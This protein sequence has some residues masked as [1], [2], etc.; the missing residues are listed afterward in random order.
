MLPTL[1]D[2]VPLPVVGMALVV[3]FFV[4]SEMGFAA[5]GRFGRKTG[6]GGANDEA[7]VLATALLL[8][9]LLLGFTFSM[10]LGRYDTRRQIVVQE[11]NDIGTA[12]LRAGLV[13]APAGKALQAKLAEYARSRVSTA[14]NSTDAGVFAA[15]MALG[16]ALRD[17]IWGLTSAAIAP[18]R[19]TAQAAALVAS[20]NAVLDTAT[21]RAAAVDARVPAKVIDLLIVYAGVSTFL[22]GYVLAAYGS[23]H[24]IATLVLFILLAMTITLILD[25]DRPQS[26]DIRVSQQP[27][28]DLVADIG[29][30]APAPGPAS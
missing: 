16:A 28:I 15:R 24:R 17:Q 12:W 27:L 30:P 20:V 26:G 11:A 25:L 5:H 13:E 8:L 2:S 4:A 6:D 10:A 1:H 23:Q 22:L 3:A 7:Q 18:D 14:E 9:A 29:R 19:S 21:T